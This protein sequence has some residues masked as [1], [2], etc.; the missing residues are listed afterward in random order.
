MVILFVL[1]LGPIARV[2][3]ATSKTLA[4]KYRILTYFIITLWVL[5]PLFWILYKQQYMQDFTYIIV[6]T[7]LPILCKAVF[8]FLDLSLLNQVGATERLNNR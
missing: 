6:F 1:L 7:L 4:G 3:R 5:Y 8:G 2:A